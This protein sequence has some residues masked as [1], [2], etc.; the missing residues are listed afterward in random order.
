[1][2][3]AVDV[4]HGDVVSLTP[5]PRYR[6][7]LKKVTQLKVMDLT[8]DDATTVLTFFMQNHRWQV[9]LPNDHP[10]TIHPG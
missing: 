7:S 8:R 2:A 3:T 10:V 6:S 9:V 1:M 4:K 5:H